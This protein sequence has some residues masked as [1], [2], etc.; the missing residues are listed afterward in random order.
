[1]SL[2]ASTE[3]AAHGVLLLV[4]YTEDAEELH[5]F[6]SFLDQLRQEESS[7]WRTV[8]GI[9]PVIGLTHLHKCKLPDRRVCVCVGARVTCDTARAKRSG[10]ATWSAYHVTVATWSRA[11]RGASKGLGRTAYQC[12]GFWGNHGGGGVCVAG[13]R[14]CM[15]GKDRA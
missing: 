15:G 3:T 9:E 14:L 8:E 10:T 11:S 4:K 2:M 13:K 5:E 7:L 6:R 12:W 1:M